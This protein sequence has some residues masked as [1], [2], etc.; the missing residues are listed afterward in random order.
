MNIKPVLFIYECEFFKINKPSNKLMEK[1]FDKI[2]EI[3]EE[4]GIDNLDNPKILHYI[5]ERVVLP[6]VEDYDMGS[7][8]E[9]EFEELYNNSD[10]YGEEIS[11]MF[12]I[13]RGIA[14]D[15]VLNYYRNINLKLKEQEILLATTEAKNKLVAINQENERI[16]K[17]VE[18]TRKEQLEM[19]PKISR[20]ERRKMKKEFAKQEKEIIKQHPEW[21]KED[22]DVFLGKYKL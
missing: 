10:S 16:K 8:T 15:T 18:E 20:R 9:E 22:I 2:G 19:M 5:A 17:E 1:M 21:T 11:D 12:Y 14:L 13:L 7:L 3:Q 6:L 4:L